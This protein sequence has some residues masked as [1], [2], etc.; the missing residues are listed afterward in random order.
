MTM[1]LSEDEYRLIQLIAD[2]DAKVDYVIDILHKDKTSD[3][4]WQF[5]KDKLRLQSIARIKAFRRHGENET[6]NILIQQFKETYGQ[7]P[8]L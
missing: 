7:E 2:V 8:E 3:E 5:Q 4:K 1:A 6:A